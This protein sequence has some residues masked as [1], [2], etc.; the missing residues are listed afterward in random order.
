MGPNHAVVTACSTGAHSIGDAARMIRD[1]DADIMLAGGAE[2]T[3]CP[4]GMAGFAQACPL[5]MISNDAPEKASLP[6][7]RGRDGFA[8]GEGTRSEERRGGTECD[9]SSRSRLT[10]DNKQKTIKKNTRE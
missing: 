1:G 9:I 3:I 7:H 5:H 8:M 4:I 6:Y 2:S 10:P